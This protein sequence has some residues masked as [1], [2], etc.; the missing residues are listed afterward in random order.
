MALALPTSTN[1]R[2]FVLSCIKRF[3]KGLP[4]Q[5][6][7]DRLKAVY[8]HSHTAYSSLGSRT[9]DLV[10]A[11]Y[12]QGK[13]S[14][15]VG[16]T[17]GVL[18]CKEIVPLKQAGIP[19]VSG[20]T[21]S[22]GY[23]V[24]V[25]VAFHEN[26][27]EFVS[28]VQRIIKCVFEESFGI[29]AAESKAGCELNLRLILFV[30][31]NR[32]LNKEINTVFK[33]AVQSLSEQV[34]VVGYLWSTQWKVGGS[35]VSLKHARRY[36]E[37]YKRLDPTGAETW[38]ISQEECALKR[39]FPKR[40]FQH[41]IKEH[42][43]TQ[44]CGAALEIRNRWLS[45]IFLC[46]LSEQFKTLRKETTGHFSRYNDLLSRL[47][48]NYFYMRASMGF[49]YECTTPVEL[50]ISNR[51]QSYIV[52]ALVRNYPT[53]HVDFPTQSVLISLWPTPSPGK[54]WY[55]LF[56]PFGGIVAASPDPCEET[57]S[58]IPL[59]TLGEYRGIY[60]QGDEWA[61]F[62]RN[63]YPK[64]INRDFKS[65]LAKLYENFSP[66]HIASSMSF[67]DLGEIYK[68]I[69]ALYSQEDAI[70]L[71]LKKI[72]PQ[73]EVRRIVKTAYDCAV[74]ILEALNYK[75]LVAL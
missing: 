24:A 42:A 57:L 18:S 1:V 37:A 54:P 70:I 51:I 17:E 29:S 43:L 56:T 23:V 40:D 50:Q 67:K 7:L 28:R 19:K 9:V 75:D 3:E 65:L 72:L 35:H 27:S 66:F 12:L 38:R 11:D 36:Y 49:T 30:H 31:R 39:Q 15:L 13:I 45:D 26:T 41:V 74:N 47:P 53:L 58:P 69:C 64:V 46:F 59:A 55:H 8:G 63:A 68:K 2:P 10:I 48:T 4:V 32:S 16:T 21:S 62:I 5:E 60:I 25:Q 71:A 44:A 73:E 22:K 14:P 34:P 52:E 33:K 61:D 20:E 6:D